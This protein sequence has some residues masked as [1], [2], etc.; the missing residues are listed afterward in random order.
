MARL[1]WPIVLV[2]I[3]SRLLQS[4]VWI[5]FVVVITTDGLK[6][7]QQQGNELRTAHKLSNHLRRMLTVRMS[8][9]RIS[10]FSP[11]FNMPKRD[12]HRMLYAYLFY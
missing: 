9:I 10:R 7:L 5:V 11:F 8:A 2:A 12:R 4:D 1:I 3:R 6:M